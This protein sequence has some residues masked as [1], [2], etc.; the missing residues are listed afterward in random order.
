MTRL[1]CGNRRNEGCCISAVYLLLV[2]VSRLVSLSCEKKVCAL[3]RFSIALPRLLNVQKSFLC[4][5]NKT[6]LTANEV[7]HHHHEAPC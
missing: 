2:C 5:V 1:F 3:V 6:R 7:V 4:S